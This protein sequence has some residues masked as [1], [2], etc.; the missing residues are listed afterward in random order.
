MPHF[1]LLQKQ[2]NIV[3]RNGE[4]KK[5]LKKGNHKT[6]NNWLHWWRIIVRLK[7]RCHYPLQWK[8]MVYIT[9][10]CIIIC[11]V[12]KFK[13]FSFIFRTFYSLLVT[14]SFDFYSSF[15]SHFRSW[16]GIYPLPSILFSPLTIFG[17]LFRI[18]TYAT[19]YLFSIMVINDYIAWKTVCPVGWMKS[20]FCSLPLDRVFSCN[21]AQFQYINWFKWKSFYAVF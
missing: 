16:N 18:S 20:G 2:A 17:L 15:C 7:S 13:S 12:S 4:L 1:L 3:N 5:W 8:T 6:K 10:L 9:V 19:F 11:M 21:F 14:Q